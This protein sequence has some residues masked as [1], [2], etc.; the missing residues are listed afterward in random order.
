MD[1]HFS[2]CKEESP[3]INH[4]FPL[5]P[6][7]LEQIMHSHLSLVMELQVPQLLCSQPHKGIWGDLG[8]PMA[9]RSHTSPQFPPGSALKPLVILPT[10]RGKGST[11]G[12]V[13]GGVWRCGNDKHPSGPR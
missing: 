7:H 13:A 1:S 3:G 12:C 2:L 6:G 11:R 10:A 8:A 9:G 4:G 5:F